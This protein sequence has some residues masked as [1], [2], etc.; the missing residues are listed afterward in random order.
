MTITAQII[1]RAARVAVAS[2]E[3]ALRLV[4]TFPRPFGITGTSA[5]RPIPREFTKSDWLPIL[6]LLSPAPAIAVLLTIPAT[7]E[8]TTQF[9]AENWGSI[10]SVW[11]LIVSFYLLF[12]ATGARRAAQ[13]AR[14]AEKL[15]TALAGLEDA[16]AK[17]IQVG[18]FARNEKWDVVELRAQEVMARCRTTLA[19]WGDTPALRESRNKLLEVATLMESIIQES[20]NANVNR[21]TILDAQLDSDVKLSVVVGR[22]QREH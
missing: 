15:R 10:A 5:E 11:G 13:E 9:T 6:A 22:I 17:C 18:Q 19:A 21:K 8:A 3:S 4:S 14:S 20:R 12:V 2:A 1:K 16:A 7:R